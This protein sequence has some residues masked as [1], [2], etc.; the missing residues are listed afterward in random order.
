MIT[1][2][3]DNGHAMDTAVERIFDAIIK[4]KPE[5][6]QTFGEL[7]R[8]VMLKLYEDDF[9]LYPS[10]AVNVHLLVAAK[11]PAEQHVEAWSIRCSMVRKMHHRE[12]HGVGGLVQHIL[13]Y[14]YIYQMPVD[15]G[16]LAMAQLLT[17]AKKHV[18][19]VGGDSYISVLSDDGKLHHE[20][21]RFSP[22]REGLF[23]YFLSCGRQLLLAT[24]KK[25]LTPEQYDAI[26]QKFVSDLKWY[27]EKAIP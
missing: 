18:V 22:E 8:D 14:L 15:D 24:G 12:I 2:A 13:D 25:A 3:C 21:L 27:R 4:Q 5:Y 6:N 17:F 19:S 26:A 7:L 10:E 16:I 20:N 11:V 1:G 9:R 23:D